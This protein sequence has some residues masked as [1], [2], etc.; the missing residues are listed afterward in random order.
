[1][2]ADE[3]PDSL[4]G[5]TR[6]YDW[7]RSFPRLLID[8]ERGLYEPPR[9]PVTGDLTGGLLSRRITPNGDLDR[10]LLSVSPKLY[11]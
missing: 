9:G 1:V 8:R 6:L 3:I 10:R 11:I 7:Y 5:L 4:G 2:I